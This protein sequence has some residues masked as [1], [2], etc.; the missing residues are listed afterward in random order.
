MVAG[1]LDSSILIDVIR[2][3]APAKV[4]FAS[5][6]DLAISPF[7]QMEF[8]A[9][10]QNKADQR[11]ALRVVARLETVF[12]TQSDIEWAMRQQIALSLSHNVGI[13]DC[14]IASVSHRMGLPLFTRNLKHFTPLLGTLAQQPY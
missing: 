11:R 14:L 6:V 5:Q 1:F 9:G 7:V 10:A 2:E 8:V 13:L 3:Y 12:P 4:W